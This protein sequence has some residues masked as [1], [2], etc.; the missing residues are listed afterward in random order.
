MM[1]Y[2]IKISII[3]DDEQQQNKLI[4]FKQKYNWND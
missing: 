1:V 3:M 2:F 4:V